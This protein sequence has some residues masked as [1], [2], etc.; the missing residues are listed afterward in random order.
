MARAETALTPAQAKQLATLI[1]ELALRGH[2]VH[3]LRGGG[4]LL[5]RRGLT[6]HCP[7]F[8]HLQ[9][10]ARQILGVSA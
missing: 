9:A 6:K 1:A 2:E 8:V 5:A 3:E 4:Y 10:A 7:T